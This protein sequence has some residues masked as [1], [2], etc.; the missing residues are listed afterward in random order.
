M[1]VRKVNVLN[2]VLDESLDEAGFQHA[3]AAIADRL[4]AQRIGASVYEAFADRSIWPY[5][6]HYSSEEWLYVISGTPVLRDA[7]GRRA[8]CC[9]DLVC[10]ASDHRGAHTVSGPGRFII[11]STNESSGP[12]VSVY[13]DSDKISVSPGL[14]ESTQLNALTLPRSRAVDYWHGEGTA[15][16]SGPQSAVREPTGTPSPAVIN[17]L[18]VPVGDRGTDVASALPT[19]HLGHDLGG[20]GLKASLVEVDPGGGSAP[21]HYQYG[22][23]E[24]VMILGGSAALRH[25]EGE[26]L[27]A[28]G[29]VVCFA[30]GPGGAHRILNHGSDPL[31]AIFLSTTGLPANVCYPDRGIWV[32]SNAPDDAD[33]TLHDSDPA[34]ARGR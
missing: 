27:L 14:H 21:Y 20:V 32:L 24:W 23:E 3:A 28:A 10:F 7:G 19:V 9:G 13:P 25:A 31:R 15:N 4:G 6:Y 11:F 26:E 22:R 18:G 2:C 33:I 30:E 8:L 17:T 12:W 16:R 34:N 1:T 29:D 5:H